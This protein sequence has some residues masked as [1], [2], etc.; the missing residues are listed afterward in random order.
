[1]KSNI[2][3]IYLYVPDIEKSYAF[4]EPLFEYFEYR[5]LYKNEEMFA[6]ISDSGTSFYF[7][8]TREKHLEPP[9][10]RCRSGLNHIAFHVHDKEDVDTFA[11][12]FLEKKGIPA[13]YETPKGFPEYEKDY[14]A[15]YFEDP[16]R[17]KLEVAYYP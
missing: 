7:E 10:H 9:F 16:D 11:G 13:M 15:V 3:H 12:E 8:L 14:Y 17:L 4:Y 6:F 2:G 5:K 1:M